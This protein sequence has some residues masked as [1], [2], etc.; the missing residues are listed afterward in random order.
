MKS[1]VLKKPQAVE[2]DVVENSWVSEMK[3]QMQEAT[4]LRLI[5]KQSEEA[6]HLAGNNTSADFD[7]FEEKYGLNG[8]A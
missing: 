4:H 6:A 2:F 8:F 1:A 7:E 5:A 3:S